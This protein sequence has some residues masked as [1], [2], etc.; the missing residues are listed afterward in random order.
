[1]TKS[2]ETSGQRRRILVIGSTGHF[3]ATA[4]VDWI[5]GVPYV[6]DFDAVVVNL[7]TLDSRLLKGLCDR[8]EP[9]TGFPGGGERVIN[10]LASLRDDFY[11]LLQS[12]G[13]VYCIVS[14]VL[15]SDERI[16]LHEGGT[17]P[18][19]TSLE[20]SPIK[21]KTVQKVGETVKCLDERF[22]KYADAIGR[23][24]VYIDAEFDDSYVRAKACDP[25]WHL[26]VGS[27]FY[28][29]KSKVAVETRAGHPLVVGV[30]W[31][32]LSIQ[33]K[34]VYRSGTLYILI[35]P[36]RVS[37]SEGID[38]LLATDMERERPPHWLADIVVPNTSKK[39]QQIAEMSEH[40][41]TLTREIE[42][43]EA[44]RTLLYS[45]GKELENATASAFSEMGFS[46]E[47]RPGKREDLLVRGGITDILVEVKGKS[48]SIS[49]GDLRQLAQYTTDAEIDRQNVKGLLVGN[50][51]R[52]MPPTKR[53]R[54]F[55]INVVEFA[56]PRNIALLT[57]VDL[58]QLLCAY[59]EGRIDRNS[60]ASLIQES[61]GAVVFP[62][63]E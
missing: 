14:R 62:E 33:S 50:H 22:Q 24:K 53:R 47:A 19:Y 40:M 13:E 28:G 4:Y 34:E 18:W 61:A 30:Y 1:M 45:S 42:D 31:N 58:F 56:K 39:R 2:S 25:S 5:Q 16:A 3:G 9:N 35:A 17:T 51:Y 55:P 43:Q 26:F 32:S 6:A 49:L 15:E 63:I 29:L 27:G 41:T 59:R 23:W 52:L 48:K 7:T 60:I 21:F 54:A 11:A 20:W 36:S 8:R 46:V 44:C 12:G 57:A 10:V 38:L 37:T